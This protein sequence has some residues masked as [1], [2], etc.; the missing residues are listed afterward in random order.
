MV[1][2]ISV[3]FYDLE[4]GKEIPMTQEEEGKKKRNW[5]KI[6]GGFLAGVFS[7]AVIVGYG[8]GGGPYGV[9]KIII[10]PVGRPGTP[11]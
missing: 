11:K 1:E 8:L 10:T 3:K 2:V 4:T 5:K 6:L 9:H 7:V